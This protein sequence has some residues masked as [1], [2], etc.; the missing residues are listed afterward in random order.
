MTG[1][2][3]EPQRAENAS[4]AP[5]T[6]AE[7]TE[8]AQRHTREAIRQLGDLIGKKQTKD[9]LRLA[10]IEEMLNRGYGRPAP[11]KIGEYGKTATR[12]VFN[13]GCPPGAK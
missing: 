12:V 2:D 8:L 1:K 3:D 6:L 5:L 11:T 10:A 7:A 4:D 9:H 13:Y